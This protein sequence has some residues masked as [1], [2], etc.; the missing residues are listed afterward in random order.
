MDLR[1]LYEEVILDHNRNPHNYGRKPEPCSHS[2]QG[3]NPLCGDEVTISLRV[4]DGVITDATFDGEGC[5]IS[6]AS[7]SLLTD[8]V[9]GRTVAEAS[10]MFERVHALVTD[11]AVEPDID[12]LGKLAVLAGVREFPMRVKCASLPWHTMQAALERPGAA[13]STE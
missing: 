4:E 12:T 13:V 2:A 5:A 11:P 7:A 6:T 3:N 1:E 9:R 10:A 8:A